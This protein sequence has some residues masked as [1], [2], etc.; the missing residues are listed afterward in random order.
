MNIPWFGLGLLGVKLAA[1]SKTVTDYL[2][3]D[4]S[5]YELIGEGSSLATGEQVEVFREA[6]G[7]P[8]YYGAG[9]GESYPADGYDCSGYV[10]SALR[11][12]GYSL[13][14]DA[15]LASCATMM[16][17]LGDPVKLEYGEEAPVGS[18]VAYG[19]ADRISHVVLSTG[20][21]VIG[22]SGG[23]SSTRGDDPNAYVKEFSTAWYRDDLV[24]YWTV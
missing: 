10:D 20:S 3:G 16:D 12:A 24:G 8:Y 1:R 21:G 13:P 9:R 11:A 19:D 17:V 7:V 6:L 23:T 2:D 18:I 4:G 22:A 5:D 15:S 14:W